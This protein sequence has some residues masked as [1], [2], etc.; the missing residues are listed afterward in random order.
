MNFWTLRLQAYKH[1]RESEE[2]RRIA[3]WDALRVLVW[4]AFFVVGLYAHASLIALQG[5]FTAIPLVA[6]LTT[7]GTFLASFV[8][9]VMNAAGKRE[10]GLVRSA[11]EAT[12]VEERLRW[13][14]SD[15][16]IMVVSALL[17]AIAGLLWLG[18]FV[19]S[20]SE[21][22]ILT[23]ILLGFGALTAINAIRLPFQIW[24]LQSSSLADE[25][26]RA[27]ERLNKEASERFKP[28]K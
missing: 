25:K 11:A 17:T 12:Q 2:S 7:F 24:E 3:G 5:S 27:F 22:L 4:A 28:E 21:P 19:V 26:K 1:V 15:Q 18:F 23:A 10:L 20:Q 13:L 14:L 16:L 9:S 8:L 6:A